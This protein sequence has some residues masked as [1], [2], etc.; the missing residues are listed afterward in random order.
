MPCGRR[1]ALRRGLMLAL[2]IGALL[3]AVPALAQT[4]RV[5]VRITPEQG[6]I[7][8]AALLDAD[9]L[10]LLYPAEGRIADYSLGGELR[11]HIVRE[12]GVERRFRPTACVASA[13]D[14]VLVFDEAAHKVL[15]VGADGNIRRGI[16]LAY[17]DPAHGLLALS[18]VGDL[19]LGTGDVIWAMLPERGVLAGF[20]LDGRHIVSLDLA[21]M[22]PYA[23]AVYSRAQV[24]PDGSLFVMEYN[25]GAVL[26]RRGATGGFH[27]IKL[28][29]TAGVDAA[30]L[31]QDFAVD[32]VGNV[33]LATYDETQ[34]LRLLTPGADGY[35][36]HPL[37]IDLPGDSPRLACRHS[38]GKYIV[39]TRDEPL[40]I[41]L[42]VTP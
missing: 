40:L 37:E 9:H 16:D 25:Q 1:A 8:D 19:A 20:D 31:L 33:L 30:P 34:P 12:A 14:S 38:G 13:A 26:Y 15:F 22:L 10:L 36:S 28:E 39:W 42:E 7:V 35:Y 24:L 18:R 21:A 23:P 3:G 4:A 11:Q 17:P 27:R 6:S 32:A 2:A 41:V 5:V 29:A